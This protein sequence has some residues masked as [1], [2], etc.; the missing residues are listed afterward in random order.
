MLAPLRSSR[1]TKRVSSPHTPSANSEHWL[2]GYMV[3]KVYDLFVEGSEVHTIT[4]DPLLHIQG[5]LLAENAPRDGEAVAHGERERE[6]AMTK[7]C[8]RA[9]C[10]NH[11]ELHTDIRASLPCVWILDTKA[12]WT[13]DGGQRVHALGW[14]GR[15]P[16]THSYPYLC[17]VSLESE[18]LRSA[19]YS[20]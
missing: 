6:T 8:R 19:R 10:L 9:A 12:W 16:Y 14:K 1:C 15:P 3:S 13:V 18:C 4:R 5:D 20:V 11:T 2:K 7:W 17:C